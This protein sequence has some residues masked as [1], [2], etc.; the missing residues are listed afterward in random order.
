MIAFLIDLAALLDR[1][2]ATAAPFRARVRIEK[3]SRTG[4]RTETSEGLLE[5]GRWRGPKVEEALLDVLRLPWSRLRERY[6][7]RQEVEPPARGERKAP[8]PGPS[9]AIEEDE[10]LV[11]LLVS[12]AGTLK[13]RLD[14]KTLRTTRVESATTVITLHGVREVLDGVSEERR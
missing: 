13:A 10:A 12:G 7:V 3:T 11:L 6:E 1:A 14:P 8:R 9:M 5:T 4:D 2:D